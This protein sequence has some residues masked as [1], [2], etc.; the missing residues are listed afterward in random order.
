MSK[1]KTPGF[2]GT[3]FLNRCPICRQ[4]SLW[5]SSKLYS[6]K[7]VTSMHTECPKCKSNLQ[8][9][10]GFYFG[11][12]YVSYALTVALWVSVYVAL[13]TFDAIGLIKFSIFDNLVTFIVTGVVTLV[14]LTPPIYRLSRSIWASMFLDFDPEKAEK[15]AE[16]ES[17]V[18]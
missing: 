2:L 8:P 5:K 18:A 10:P 4:G 1:A 9:E 14:I 17:D 15:V 12:A 16:K 3:V 13:T 6:P 7:E 11:A